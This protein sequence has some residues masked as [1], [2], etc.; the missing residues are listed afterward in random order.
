[1]NGNTETAGARGTT[2]NMSTKEATKKSSDEI[3][4]PM[5]I[6]EALLE[7]SRHDCKDQKLNNNPYHQAFSTPFADKGPVQ[8]AIVEIGLGIGAIC[9]IVFGA[10]VIFGLIAVI[11]FFH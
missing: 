8:H 7:K 10:A 1:M 3:C 4:V 9:L 11:F 2:I 5:L 6:W